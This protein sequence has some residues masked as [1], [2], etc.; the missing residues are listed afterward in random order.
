MKFAKLK[1]AA[2]AM[3]AISGVCS[4]QAITASAAFQYTLTSQ[5][6]L[7]RQSTMDTRVARWKNSYWGTRFLPNQ[8]FT[9]TIYSDTVVGGFY[10][11]YIPGGYWQGM[12][13]N[14]TNGQ[15][16]ARALAVDY[17]DTTIFMSFPGGSKEFS[18]RIGD[19]ICLTRNGVT[20]FIF[21]TRDKSGIKAVELVDGKIKYDRSYGTGNGFMTFGSE[22]WNVAHYLRPIKEGDA[23]GDSYV[24]LNGVHNFSGDDSYFQYYIGNSNLGDWGN[25]KTA[26]LTMNDDWSITQ[27]DYTT[28]YNNLYYN[29]VNGCMRGNFGFIKS[30]S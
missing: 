13:L 1:I 30:L 6:V 16:L 11:S 27:A 20:K 28:W 3:A 25:A 12:S 29:S 9:E 26:A 4:M 18:P 22:R 21:I 2:I 15:G 8:A 24:Y 5:E 10:N 17:F 19:Q 14:K 7:E 23:N